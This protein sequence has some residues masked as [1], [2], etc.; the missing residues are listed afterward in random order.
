[1][2]ERRPEI[3]PSS[4]L[5]F[6]NRELSRVARLPV[7]GYGHARMTILGGPGKALRTRRSSGGGGDYSDSEDEGRAAAAVCT[8]FP[9]A[10][11]E[12]G[13]VDLPW[14]IKR[15]KERR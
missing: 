15:R 14:Q 6:L 13:S 2:S 11:A 5:T 8:S 12:P 10:T 4:S 3:K 7:H 1:M 9:R